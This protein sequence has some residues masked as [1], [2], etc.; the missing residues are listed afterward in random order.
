MRSMV[1][2]FVRT[3]T[4]DAAD[5]VIIGLDDSLPERLFGNGG[6]DI[7]IGGAGGDTLSGG[8]GSDTASYETAPAGV[9]ASLAN[10]SINIGHAAGDTYFQLESLTGSGFDDTLIGNAI[11]NALT[12]GAG[13]DT[14][15]GGAGPRH[16]RW[17][18]G[19]RHRGVRRQ[20]GGLSRQPAWNRRHPDHRH[21]AGLA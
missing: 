5:D 12:G 21:A 4:G 18:R 8:A 6:N 9:A 2:Q 14:L 17:R 7:L 3:H 13:N 1:A 11:A 20:S 19:Q 16:D 10:P 15:V